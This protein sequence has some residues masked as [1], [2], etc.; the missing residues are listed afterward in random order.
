LKISLRSPCVL[1]GSRSSPVG[2]VRT[3]LQ[4]HRGPENERVCE[5][6]GGE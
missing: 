1:L 2:E 4:I 3:A 6:P 5:C